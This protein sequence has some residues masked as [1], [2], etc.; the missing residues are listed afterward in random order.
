MHVLC[1]DD[2][3]GGG[4]LLRGR[5]QRRHDGDALLSLHPP[6]LPAR[7]PNQRS[8]ISGSVLGWV[9]R[10]SSCCANLPHT[11]AS[12]PTVLH[13]VSSTADTRPPSAFHP[14]PSL[15]TQYRPATVQPCP[16]PTLPTPC[17]TLSHHPS[18]LSVQPAPESPWYPNPFGFRPVGQTPSPLAHDPGPT[19]VLNSVYL[20]CAP[21]LTLP[22]A[23][24]APSIL[25]QAQHRASPDTNPCGLCIS[26]TT[27]SHIT[28]L[29][30]TLREHWEGAPAPSSASQLRFRRPPSRERRDSA[31]RHIGARVGGVGAHLSPR[32]QP[33][34][35][36][37]GG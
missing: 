23:P 36:G 1:K 27:T 32:P 4:G 13:H 21:P 2:V 15:P 17:R 7:A 33:N 19:L 31:H 34:S 3:R 25:V 28:P 26:G 11:P 14:T 30:D 6:L 12:Q 10:R 18:P 16:V 22:T 20:H 9:V 29:G 5:T 35:P 24:A 37:G 8:A